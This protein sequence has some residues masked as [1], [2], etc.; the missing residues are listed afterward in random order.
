MRYFE[1]LRMGWIIEMVQIYGFINRKH[2][3]K[4]FGVTE[5]VVSKDFTNVMKLHPALMRYDVNDK[6][7]R[8]KDEL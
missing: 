1:N 8:L 4:K 7:Y 6:C 5:Q 2:V 3:V